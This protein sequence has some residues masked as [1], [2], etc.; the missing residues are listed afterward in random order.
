MSHFGEL[1]K[2]AR[3]RT[4]HTQKEL[5]EKVGVDDSYI[6]RLERGVYQPPSREVAEGL[7]DATSMSNK[8]V[9]LY[10]STKEMDAIDRFVFLLEANV[11]GAEDVKEIRLVKI[12]DDE[13]D[14]EED[15]A[16]GGEE[17]GG[18]RPT[19]QKPTQITAAPSNV[20]A[21]TGTFGAP[22]SLKDDQEQQLPTFEEQVRQILT[23]TNLPYAKRMIAQQMILEATRIVCWGLTEAED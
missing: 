20:L 23:S 7:A 15:K 4:W 22:S 5:G 8:P 14:E 11:A 6:S 21:A 16:D 10:V 9:T 18:G 3:Q 2:K 13:T 12:E 1:L 17:P 19:I